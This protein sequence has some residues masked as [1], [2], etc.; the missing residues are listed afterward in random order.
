MKRALLESWEFVSWED[1]E[2]EHILIV[3]GCDT[4][5]VETSEFKDKTVHWLN[6]EESGDPTIEILKNIVTIQRL[7]HRGDYASKHA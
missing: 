5:C 4:A 3:A 1:S 7:L 6:S 2:A